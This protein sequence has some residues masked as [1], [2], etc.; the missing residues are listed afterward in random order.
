MQGFI[1]KGSVVVLVF[2]CTKKLSQEAGHKLR[3]KNE[4]ARFDTGKTEGRSGRGGGPQAPF[5]HTLTHLRD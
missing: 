4:T 5:P 3:I 1:K 2:M